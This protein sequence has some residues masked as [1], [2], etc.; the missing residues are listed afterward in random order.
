MTNMENFSWFIDAIAR[1]TANVISICDRWKGNGK[2]V[3]FKA[4]NIGK[5]FSYDL[6]KSLS[7]KIENLVI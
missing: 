1:Y 4:K 2:M 5:H 7:G 3:A 6:V